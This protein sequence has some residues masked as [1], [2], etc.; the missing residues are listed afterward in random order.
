MATTYL[1]RHTPMHAYIKGRAARLLQNLQTAYPQTSH[2]IL[3]MSSSIFF[4]EPS[5]GF[6]RLFRE[7]FDA[8][9]KPDNCGPN[10]RVSAQAVRR[11]ADAEQVLRPK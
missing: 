4:Y 11:G 7:A 2:W 8:R 1:A 9:R 6:D 5:Y 10:D 3:N